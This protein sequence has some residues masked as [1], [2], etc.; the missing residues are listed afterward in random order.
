VQSS[1]DSITK[2][3]DG[4]PTFLSFKAPKEK[5]SS[6]TITILANLIN[7]DG[8]EHI[9]GVPSGIINGK[10]VS[11]YDFKDYKNTVDSF[12]L[13]INENSGKTVDIVQDHPPV[14]IP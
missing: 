5:D 12:A 8:Y 7:A 4:S 9:T 2:V 1:F 10:E 14:F 13:G 11:N 6:Q 3:N